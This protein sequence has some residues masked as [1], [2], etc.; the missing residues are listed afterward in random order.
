MMQRSILEEIKFQLNNGKMTVR[1][2]IVNVIVFIAIYIV[3]LIEGL[4]GSSNIGLSL[5]TF[6]TSVLE[7]AMKPWTLFTSII[8]HFSLGHLFFNMLFLFF[9]GSMF[10]QVF[11]GKKLLLTYIFGGIMGNVFELT[12]TFLFP[13]FSPPHYVVGAS[14]AIM[15]VFAAI[16]VYR[17][18]TPIYLFGIIA[19]PIY[20][21][22]LF[23][24]AKDL[25]GLGASD[26]IAHFAHLGGAFFGFLAVQNIH[27]QSNI[28]NRITR[29]FERKQRTTPRKNT[30]YKTDEVF[31]SEKKAKQERIDE[32][33]D[34]ISKSG[35]ES[36]S[37]E[38]K[39][40]L[41][42]QGQK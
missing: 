41:F 13:D 18:Q 33:L 5:F 25:I 7:F 6:P 24:L 28:L 40:Y 9:A 35:Y 1:L 22:A 12:I 3:G 20:V 26:E 19:I 4:F 2:I 17:P 29:L 37:R 38:E 34:K 32:I 10:E 31:N 39:D 8:A 23:F 36:L 11:G 15:A 27:S 30:R 14:G 42:N 16:A 21:L